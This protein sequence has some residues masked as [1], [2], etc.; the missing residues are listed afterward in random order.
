MPSDSSDRG[1]KTRN[2][3]PDYQKTSRKMRGLYELVKNDASGKE[4]WLQDIQTQWTMWYTEGHGW[5][6]SPERFVQEVDSNPSAL[7]EV[8]RFKEG[9]EMRRVQEKIADRLRVPIQ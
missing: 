5:K 8:D 7:T 6:T 2:A 9:P 4:S 1:H 3:F